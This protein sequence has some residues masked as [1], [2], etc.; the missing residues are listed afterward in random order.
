MPRSPAKR[1][2]ASSCSFQMRRKRNLGTAS[3]SGMFYLEQFRHRLRRPHDIE[4]LQR[5]RKIIT[6]QGCDP[7]AEYAGQRRARFVGLL[8]VKRMAG[9]TGAKHFSAVVAG[10][11]G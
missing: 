6:R 4:A 11:G 1:S 2:M 3:I 8:G 5:F 9:H 7:P 10:I